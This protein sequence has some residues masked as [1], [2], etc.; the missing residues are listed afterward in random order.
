M[1]KH[2]KNNGLTTRSLHGLTPFHQESISVSPPINLTTNYK[3]NS[4]TDHPPFEYSRSNNPNR[5]QL[6]H[7]LSLLDSAQSSVAFSSGLA[8]LDAVMQVIKKRGKLISTPTIYGG[9]LRLF[10]YYL[11]EYPDFIL[12]ADLNN[13]SKVEELM[14]ENHGGSI[15]F[16]SISNPLLD[17]LDIESLVSLA[18]RY[19]F[20]VIVDN[21]F[22]TPI[23]FRPIEI[24][25]DMVIHSSTKYLGG[26]SDLVG[27]IISLKDDEFSKELR[28][29]QNAKGAVPSP[30]DCWLFNRSLAT[31]EL[32]MTCHA[33]NAKII[34][35]WLA[36]HSAVEMVRHPILLGESSPANKLFQL[37]CGVVSVRFRK[38]FDMDQFIKKLSYFRLAESLGGVESLINFPWHMTHGHLAENDRLAVGVTPELLRFS[39]GIENINDLVYDLKQA[40]ED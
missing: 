1:K 12:L 10:N 9:T 39:I 4:L 21:T 34:A 33:S 22:L 19:D 6:E 23:F 2:T 32:R 31:L 3:F 27:G 7:T 28:F 30:F 29:I 18:K 25:V 8:A 5:E 26:H 11:K 36:P 24:G 13:L 17:V 16:E 37:K 14:K 35:E 20:K 15:L 38:G 40:L